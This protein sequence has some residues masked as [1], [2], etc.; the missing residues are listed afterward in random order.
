MRSGVILAVGAALALAGLSG[1][2]HET[3][4]AAAATAAP[5]LPLE[6]G[7]FTAQSL[8]G[9]KY[10]KV[11]IDFSPGDHQSN[12][13]SGMAGCNRFNGGYTQ[14]ATTMKFGPIMTSMMMCPDEQMATE[15]KF[16]DFL[17][18]VE[19]WHL[20]ANGVLTLTT[21]KGDVQR[22]LKN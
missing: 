11:T 21:G 15:R 1:C 17:A 5:G 20:D 2:A 7:S 8:G 22:F 16:L 4:P 18:A 14:T 9:G 19:T 3:K 13:A 6:S 10:P 12:H